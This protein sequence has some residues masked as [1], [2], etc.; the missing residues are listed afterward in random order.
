MEA[1][2]YY[3]RLGAMIATRANLPHWS[4]RCACF[5][6]FRLADSLPQEKL[7]ALAAEREAWFLAHPEPWDVETERE[8]FDLFDDR[9]QKWL[10]LGAGACL[11]ARPGVRDIV[12]SSLRHFADVRYALYSFVVMPNHV[13]VLF[14]PT[15]G[16]DV[17][18]I[19]QG[20]KGY[21]A[22]AIN[23]A[24]GR[25][26]SVWQKESWD[27]LVRNVEQFNAYRAYIRGNNA[28]LAYDAYQLIAR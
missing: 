4:Q 2:Q 18:S 10:D 27:R 12:E 23:V 22:K 3:S 6:T 19:M 8:Y 26:G 17:P 1:P 7:A 14:M 13:H 25:T 5:A 20:W 24:L 11:L 15:E 28:S 9:V 16:F 21:T